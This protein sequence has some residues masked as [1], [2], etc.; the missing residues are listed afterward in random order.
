[1]LV[2]ILLIL[3]LFWFLGYGPFEA[4]RI[5]L[6]RLGPEVVTL[7]DILIFLLIIWLIDLLPRPLREIA[8]V[9]LLI[10]LLSLFGIL[11][12]AG[13]NNIIIWAIIIGLLL[14]ILSGRR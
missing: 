10:W 11:A 13:L 12:F 6:F 3:I 5:P 2:V 1:M 9:L 8:I 4:L 14:Y 7:W